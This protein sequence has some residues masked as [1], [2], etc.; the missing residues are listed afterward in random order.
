MNRQVKQRGAGQDQWGSR[1]G[2]RPWFGP[3]RVG[4]GLRPQ[5]WQGYL[6]TGVITALIVVIAA[7]ARGHWQSGLLI[8]LI[9]LVLF[10]IIGAVTRR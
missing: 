7:A 8:A 10:A 4:Y 5:S 9:P 2:R 3:K 1:L 6:L